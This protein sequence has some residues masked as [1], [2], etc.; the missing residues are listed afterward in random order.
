MPTGPFLL[1]LALVLNSPGTDD[2]TLTIS[3]TCNAIKLKKIRNSQS[4][5]ARITRF[6]LHR[7]GSAVELRPHSFHPK[8]STPKRR[9]T[10]PFI[11]MENTIDGL[12]EHLITG[13]C[14]RQ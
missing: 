13:R 9:G 11:G 1:G 10:F 8:Y 4:L 7:Y 12:E 2:S 14:S 3:R 6:R 5:P